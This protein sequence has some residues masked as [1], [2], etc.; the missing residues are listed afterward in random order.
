LRRNARQEIA[1]VI[2]PG[3]VRKRLRADLPYR[4]ASKSARKRRKR[5]KAD[6]PP[7]G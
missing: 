5:R 1:E 3:R 4:Q 6:W 7:A 2:A